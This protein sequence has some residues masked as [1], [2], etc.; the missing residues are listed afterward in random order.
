MKIST[1]IK[2][3]IV[4]CEVRKYSPRTIKTYKNNLEIFN[5]FCEEELEL[6]D[7]DDFTMG[8]VK[9]FSQ[10]L[11]KNGRKGTYVNTH[12]KIIKSWMHYCY[13][14]EYISINP[15]KNFKWAKSDKPV[16][17]AF[18]PDDVKKILG[19]CKGNDYRSV[20][21]NCILTMLFET[22]IRS[23]ELCM[24]QP[25]DIHED[26]ILIHGKGGKERVCALTPILK[27]AMFRYERAREH[28]F[29]YN[30]TDDYY[31]LSYR[32]KMLTNSALRHML[33]T[34]GEGITNVRLSPHTARHFFATQQVKMKTDVYVIS[35]LLGHENLKTTETYLA[36]LKDDD[37]VEIAKN[38]SVLM[39]L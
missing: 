6:T 3:Y 21:D 8:T 32:G 28:Y 31:F 2:E 26:F 19:C 15:K 22:G 10:M 34:R 14:E 11:I 4:E 20:R 16:I 12:L 37:V 23:L 17:Q 35:K 7:I 9:Q 1:A 24:I 18:T 36:T 30:M 38:N 29:A 27:K 33:K 25:K 5:R 39:N 13:D